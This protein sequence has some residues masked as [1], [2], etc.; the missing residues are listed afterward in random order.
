MGAAYR[1]QKCG[2]E[3][4]W[5]LLRRGDAARTWSCRADIDAVLADFQ[6]PEDYLVGTEI[7]VKRA[8]PPA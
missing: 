8:L 2:G 7:I 4:G 3:P 5:S 6:R 1:C